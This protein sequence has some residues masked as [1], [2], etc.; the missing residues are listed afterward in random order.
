[1]SADHMDFSN[2]QM[3]DKLHSLV[4]ENARL[5]KIVMEKTN[6]ANE[7][8][9]RKEDLELKMKME[10]E[11][12]DSHH[13]QLKLTIQRLQAE[14]AQRQDELSAMKM[15]AEL[16]RQNQQLLIDTLQAE[17]A[18]KQIILDNYTKQL[19]E[20]RRKLEENDPQGKLN[21]AFDITSSLRKLLDEKEHVI[22]QLKSQIEHQR[23]S[24]DHHKEKLSGVQQELEL[25][26]HKIADLIANSADFKQN[27][28]RLVESKDRQI[29]KLAQEL[30]SR[31][32]S[33]E[34]SRSDYHSKS[35]LA[36]NFSSSNSSWIAQS[37]PLT[38]SAPV[39]RHRDRDTK[40]N[41]DLMKNNRSVQ[42]PRPTAQ[43]DSQLD[44][45]YQEID[46]LQKKIMSRLHHPNG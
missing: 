35:F 37:T 8:I 30:K 43:K 23:A 15:K 29:G 39:Q 28:S 41:V 14:N 33:R 19:R 38:N 26:E 11:R 1:M 5:Q 10:M 3:A 25:K 18:D 46:S 2:K 7:Q 6:E 13:Q 42:S 22:V 34:T 4:T 12:E 9:R 44:S 36:D 31:E 21:I 27:Y 20:A 16:D 32:I 17:S 40:E 45:I 24:L